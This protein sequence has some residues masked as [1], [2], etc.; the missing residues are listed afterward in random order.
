[1]YRV[2][3]ASI[4]AVFGVFAGLTVLIVVGKVWR[5]SLAAW[6]RSRRRLLEPAILA[7]AHADAV[8][9]HAAGGA[10]L[11]CALWPCALCMA[12]PGRFSRWPRPR[13]ASSVAN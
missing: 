7:Y 5:E 10:F 6:R 13:P 1:M 8:S 11:S 12:A 2:L 3:I 9:L 4:L